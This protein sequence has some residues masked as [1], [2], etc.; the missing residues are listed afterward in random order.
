M[1]VPPCLHRCGL[2]LAFYFILNSSQGATRLLWAS[3]VPQY[4]ASA[5]ASR[6]A[7]AT[8]EARMR[9]ALGDDG[10][11]NRTDEL[12]LLPIGYISQTERRVAADGA[13]RAV[14]DKV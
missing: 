8:F 3:S 13:P 4:A 14:V 10:D 9:A 11:A 1:F 7:W 12:S 6:A 2:V 5:D